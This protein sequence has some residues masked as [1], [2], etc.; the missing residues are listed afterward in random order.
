MRDSLMPGIKFE[1]KFVVPLSKTVV[2]LY[3]LSDKF[4]QMPEVFRTGFLVGLI[5]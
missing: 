4:L 3:L 5:E 1:H 2:A